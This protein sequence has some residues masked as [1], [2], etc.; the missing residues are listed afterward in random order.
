MH[1]GGLNVTS[2]IPGRL[3]LKVDE[4]R[5]SPEYAARLRDTLGRVLG[6]H[7]VEINT[8]TGSVLVRY[9]AALVTRVENSHAL[10]QAVREL[11]PDADIAVLRT[12][13]E[14]AR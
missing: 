1:I 5:R 10:A 7:G 3:R 14:R 9:D 13:L 8:L 4:V 2:F 6:I 11:F 12:W